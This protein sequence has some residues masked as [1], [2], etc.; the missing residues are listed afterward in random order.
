MTS[1][2]WGEIVLVKPDMIARTIGE[3]PAPEVQIVDGTLRGAWAL[4]LRSHSPNTVSAAVISI[5]RE[6]VTLAYT[7]CMGADSDARRD[8]DPVI[9][10]YKAH[11]DRS[12]LRENLRRTPNERLDALMALQRFAGEARRAAVAARRRGA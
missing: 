6:A 12:L 2:N 9:E 11:I 8:R 4:K 7:W 3:L 1:D 5:L 10:A